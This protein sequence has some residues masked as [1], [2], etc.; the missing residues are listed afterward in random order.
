ML[1]EIESEPARW[2]EIER[3]AGSNSHEPNLRRR[4]RGDG[5]SNQNF[6]FFSAGI[7]GGYVELVGV[8]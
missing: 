6:S 3:E 2:S 5:D 4:E 7:G 1:R 8:V